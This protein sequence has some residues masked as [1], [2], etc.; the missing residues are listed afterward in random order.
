[1]GLQRFPHIIYQTI[2]TKEHS[3]I[4][5]LPLTGKCSHHNPT[6][7]DWLRMWNFQYFWAEKGTS[8]IPTHR[9]S[10]H[11]YNGEQH[12][13]TI[14]THWQML[15]AQSNNDWQ[16]S[17]VK[18][19]IFL[20]RK[21][22]FRDSHTSFSRPFWQRS[23]AQFNNYHSL[24]NAHSIIQQWLTDFVCKTFNISGQKRGIQRFPHII[25][26]TILKKE[27]STIQQLPLTGKCS[28]YNPI[29][30]DWLRMWNFQYFWAKKGDFRDS[31]TSFIKPFLQRST[32]QFNNY[33]SLANAHS[34]I[35]HWLTDFICETFNI[36][37][38]KREL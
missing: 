35:Q 11:F 28:Q 7:A 25:Y 29:M 17:Y 15:T 4:Q 6:L 24:A 22:E 13:S 37:G 32:A 12:N 2:F 23:T 33:H 5:Q 8:E 10:D 3:T 20:G 19:S 14:T 9:L 31:Y 16:T 18:L 38:Q 21:G 1:M 36:S 27:H 26:Q 30:T 34:K